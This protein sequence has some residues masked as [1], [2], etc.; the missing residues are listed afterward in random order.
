MNIRKFY[1]ANLKAKLIKFLHESNIEFIQHYVQ[2][3]D[4]IVRR[5]SRNVLRV[6]SKFARVEQAMSSFTKI[7]TAKALY[8][9]S[10][11]LQDGQ[12]SS[13]KSHSFRSVQ[14]LTHH[15][16]LKYKEKQRNADVLLHNH[17]F[18]KVF[19]AWTKLTRKAR[20]FRRRRQH[21]VLSQVIDAWHASSRVNAVLRRKAKSIVDKSHL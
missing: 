15:P 13:K 8:I 21:R 11:W 17:V 18:K 20:L 3:E 1:Q 9:T 2:V 14:R 16:C 5:R 6:L 10:I 19:R 7:P 12:H 4:Y